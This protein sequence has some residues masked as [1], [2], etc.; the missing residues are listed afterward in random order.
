MAGVLGGMTRRAGV[1]AIAV[2]CAMLLAMMTAAPVFAQGAPESVERFSLDSV[3]G[4]DSFGGQNVSSQPQLVIDVSAAVRIGDNWQ[5]YVRPWF[6]LPRPS[7]STATTPPWDTEIYQAGV[8]YERPGP[9]AT[10]IDAGYILSPIGLGMLD[11]RQNL[12]ANIL[13]HLSYVVPMPAFAPAAPRVLPVSNAYPLGAQLTVSSNHWDARAAV[14]NSAPTRPYV[15]GAATNPRQTPV[16]VAG[17]GITP[18]TGLRFGASFAHG[19]YATAEEITLPNAQAR[20]VTMVGGEGEW[21]FR[22]TRIRGE[23]IRS[24]F[25]VPGNAAVA[26]EWFVQGVQTLAPRWF[27]A[28]R[29]EGTS[30]PPLISGIAIGARTDFAVFEAT[31]GFRVTPDVTLRG[32][33]DQRKS[34]GASSW[35]N[36]AAVSVVWT[37][38]WW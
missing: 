16:F 36:Q 13:P 15:L 23:I 26:R 5:L 25:E 6:R 18:I 34:Y 9:I 7:S 4:I 8:R 28:A 20:T 14:V 12:N 33:Y 38:R 30:A 31:V 35:D 10:R 32:A 21:A 19:D 11:S 22:Y 2:A 27:V 3:I 24:A 37:R 17:G 29:A 1:G